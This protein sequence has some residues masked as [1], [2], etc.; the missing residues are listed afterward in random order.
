MITLFFFLVSILFLSPLAQARDKDEVIQKADILFNTE[1]KETPKSGKPVSQ[2]T[3]P[4]QTTASSQAAGVATKAKTSPTPT[5]VTSHPA[6]PSTGPSHKKEYAANTETPTSPSDS[7]PLNMKQ[8]SGPV[9]PSEQ[10]KEAPPLAGMQVVP[11]SAT[12][13][14]PSLQEILQQ[15]YECLQK[16]KKYEARSL[17]SQALFLETSEE[18]RQLIRKHLDELNNTLF[19]STTPSPDFLVYEVKPGDNLTK[20]AKQYGTTAELLMK[21]NRKSSSLIRIGEPLRVLKGRLS[22]LVDKSDFRLTLLLN[23]NYLKQYPIGIG[24]NDK[25]PEGKFI[26]E[27]KMKE[28]TWFAPDGKVYP[29]GN[30]Q[31]ILGT[32][33]ISFQNQP[34][35]TGYGIHGTT[36]PESI[37][38]DSSNGCI[39]MFN[40]D[41]E[42]LY[43]YV[44]AGMEVVIQR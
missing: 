6:P 32:R 8:A 25:T 36:E 4:P 18:R 21:L 13:G 5:K 9:S 42:E 24:R 39:R 15:A 3:A 7:K 20:I 10:K 12:E 19:F 29:Y 2:K 41:V 11:V 34:G 40:Q 31:N 27:T 23:G 1:A 30:P 33:W 37:G 14:H 44:T 17:Y 22:I 16:D 38:T 35:L 26:V 28:P 43:D